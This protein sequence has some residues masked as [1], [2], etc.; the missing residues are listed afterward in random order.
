MNQINTALISCI[1]AALTEESADCD[2]ASCIGAAYT[3]GVTNLLY[4]AAA[5]MPKEKRPEAGLMSMLKQNT[6]TAIVRET[7]QCQLL[8]EIYRR[9]EDSKIRCV[10]LK[11]VVLKELYPKPELRYMSDIDLLIDSTRASDVRKY[12][13]ELGCQVLNFDSGDTDHYLTADGLTIEVKKFLYEESF[14]PQT[15]DFL[16]KILSLAEP[17]EG[18]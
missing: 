17:M 10:A 2:V 3:H 11:G 1:R 16:S 15:W 7:M 18:Y 14:N 6:Y 9:F 12:F 13:E 4:Y 5:K 8:K